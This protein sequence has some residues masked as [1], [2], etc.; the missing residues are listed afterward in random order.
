VGVYVEVLVKYRWLIVVTAVS[1]CAVATVLTLLM[2]STYVA[3]ATLRV[4]ASAQG[5]SIDTVDYRYADRLMNTYVAILKSRP[6]IE[7]ASRRVGIDSSSGLRSM[8]VTV[9]AVPDTELMR[10]SVENTNP[11]LAQDMANALAG[12]IIEEGEALYSGGGKSAR[13]ILEEQ[14]EIINGDLE[15]DRTTLYSLMNSS[16]TDYSEIDAL[17]SRI[18][19]REETYATLLR[20]YEQA[21]VAELMRAGSISVV[22]PA[23]EPSGPSKPNKKLNI[24]LG[25]LVGLGGGASLAFLFENL[26]TTPIMERLLSLR[27]RAVE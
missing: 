6:I 15:M 23:I 14:L 21:R 1:T 26:Q 4:V 8:N 3:S 25:A 22:E 2:P 18:I 27:R 16:S 10:V 17:N 12:L 20:Q 5:G 7:E 11:T 13:E 19:L 9:E 24:A